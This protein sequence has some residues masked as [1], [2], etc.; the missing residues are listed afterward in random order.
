MIERSIIVCE[1]EKFMVDESWLSPHVSETARRSG[2]LFRMAASEEKKVI[3]TAL[4]DTQGRVAGPSGAAAKLGIPPS[5]LDSKIKLLKI[6]KHRFRRYAPNNH[7]S[8]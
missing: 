8:W 2:A 1:T 4:A 3:E 5:T 6:N 7:E